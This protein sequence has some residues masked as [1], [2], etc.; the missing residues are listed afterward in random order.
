[1]KPTAYFINVARG[2]VVDEP[3]LVRA[4]E[5]GKI[6]G[7][8]LDVRAT[9]PPGPGPFDRLDNVILT[10]HVAGFTHEAQRRVVAAVCR[11]VE[12]VLRGGAASG[13]VNFPTPRRP[14]AQPE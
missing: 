13:F 4:L 3:G 6:A 9:E 12:A 1:M 7:A 14:A 10:P 11:D 8:A 2:E 5:E